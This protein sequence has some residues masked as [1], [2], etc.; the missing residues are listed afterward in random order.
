MSAEEIVKEAASAEEGGIVE[1][2]YLVIG[3]WL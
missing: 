1:G 3:T 2:R